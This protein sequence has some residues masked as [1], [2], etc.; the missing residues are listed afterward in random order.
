LGK[1]ITKVSQQ[2]EGGRVFKKSPGKRPSSAEKIKAGKE[3]QL[4]GRGREK[5]SFH[6]RK[7]PG[8]GVGN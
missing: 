4:L 5:N 8:K 1:K 7:A 2:H 3:K 6:A